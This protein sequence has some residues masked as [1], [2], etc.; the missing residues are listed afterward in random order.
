MSRTTTRSR[1]IR[2][3]K[4]SVHLCIFHPELELHYAWVEELHQLRMEEYLY[5]DIWSNHAFASDKDV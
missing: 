1:R 3:S 4:R 2:T 5:T